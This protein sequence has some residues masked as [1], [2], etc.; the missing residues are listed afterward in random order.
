MMKEFYGDEGMCGN[1]RLSNILN[2]NYQCKDY[3]IGRDYLW[4][5]WLRYYSL[6]C[7]VQENHMHPFLSEPPPAHYHNQQSLLRESVDSL[8]MNGANTP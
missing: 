8:S 4:I 1:K 2:E 5:S 7:F 6:C 3:D